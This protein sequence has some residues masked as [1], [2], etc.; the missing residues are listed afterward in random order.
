MNELNHLSQ[1][2]IWVLALVVILLICQSTWLFIDARKHSR[3]PWFW[4]LWGLIQSPMP[5]L[6]YWLI[7]RRGLRKPQV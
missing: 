3:F 1:G 7:V 2:E 6:F 4:G 5:L